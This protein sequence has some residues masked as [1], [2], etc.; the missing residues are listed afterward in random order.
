MPKPA[1]RPNRK[2]QIAAVAALVLA[3]VGCAAFAGWTDL[4]DDTG[5]AAVLVVVGAAFAITVL[6]GKGGW[7]GGLLVGFG[8][9]LARLYADVA[10][11][12]LPHPMPSVLGSFWVLM[13]A[14]G[15]VLT[16]VALRTGVR[17]MADTRR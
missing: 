14:F 1:A 2:L 6:F 11:I 13:P 4:H 8:V 3:T 5:Q 17:S 16:G 15:A 10:K 9:P 7:L 12:Q